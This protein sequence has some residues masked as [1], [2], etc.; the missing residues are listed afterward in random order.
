PQVG[1]KLGAEAGKSRVGLPQVGSKPGAEA[2]KSRVG[3][4]QVGSKPGAEA[5]K[6]R[7][8]LPQVGGRPGAEAGGRGT[9]TVEKAK[10]APPTTRGKTLASPPTEN[11]LDP[12]Q[13]ANP[14]GELASLDPLGGVDLMGATD[15]AA[16]LASIGDDWLQTPTSSSV[17]ASPARRPEPPKGTVV[18]IGLPTLIGGAVVLL[19]V[20]IFVLVIVLTRSGGSPSTSPQMVS[21]PVGS[22][23]QPPLSTSE[24]TQAPKP[25]GTL[26]GTSLPK[27]PETSGPAA[28]PIVSLPA[29]SPGQAADKRTET[30]SPNSSFPG[31]PTSPLPKPVAPPKLDANPQPPSKPEQMQPPPSDKNQSL[32]DTRPTQSPNGAVAAPSQP[33]VGTG[34]AAKPSPP[35]PV[36]SPPPPVAE[37][38]ENQIRELLA[39]MREIAIEFKADVQIHEV[40][41]KMVEAKIKESVAT[42]GLKVSRNSTAVMRVNLTK[43]QDKSTIVF[44][45]SAEVEC[46]TDFTPVIVWSNDKE[47]GKSLQGQAADVVL[48]S[49]RSEVSDFVVP[50]LRDYRKAVATKRG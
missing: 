10:S 20:V 4:P 13:A 25:A 15:S 29:A 40:V 39:G 44:R 35:G 5:G 1:S 27:P 21:P 19:L 34:G 26:P 32:G 16:S 45:L 42:L 12:L 48:K 24:L 22:Q 11:G 7:V 46:P 8:G 9:G 38:S 3:L 23:T 36:V 49:L 14:L 41:S 37:A 17:L 28:A 30:P 6:S 50:F 33:E 31:S 18:S 2:G 47:L 43:K